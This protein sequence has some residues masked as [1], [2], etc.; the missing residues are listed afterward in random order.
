MSPVKIN[1]MSRW[2]EV[3]YDDITANKTDFGVALL[4]LLICDYVSLAGSDSL[5]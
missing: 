5:L 1:G 4:F 3:N 2:S